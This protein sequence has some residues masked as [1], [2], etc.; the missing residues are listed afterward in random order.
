[1]KTISSGMGSGLIKNVEL[2]DVL[3]E[4]WVEFLTLDMKFKPSQTFLSGSFK[5]HSP[6]GICQQSMALLNQE[7][8]LYRGLFPL[9]VFMTG[10]PAVGKTH[11]AHKLS[12]SYGVPHVKI[13]DLISNAMKLHNRFGDELRSKIEE[14]KDI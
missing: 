1:M 3:G 5:W 10:P 4:D 8:N 7:F 12:E 13:G 11:F 9:K 6:Q 2:G 14:L